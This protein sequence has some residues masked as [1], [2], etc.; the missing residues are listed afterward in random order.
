MLSLP[1]AVTRDLFVSTAQNPQPRINQHNLLQKTYNVYT[2]TKLHIDEMFKETMLQTSQTW[3]TMTIWPVQKQIPVQHYKRTFNI[4]CFF[5]YILIF[6]IN[7]I[8]PH[9]KTRPASY[10]HENLICWVHRRHGGRNNMCSRQTDAF[11]ASV[12]TKASIYMH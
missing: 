10:G 8:S 9:T 4:N 11:F 5:I 2:F 12:Q 3:L 7:E 6:F 1:I